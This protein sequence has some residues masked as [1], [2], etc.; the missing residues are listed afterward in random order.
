M[1]TKTDSDPFGTESITEVQLLNAPLA[2]VIVQIRFPQL[3]S[4]S[5]DD[6][7]AKRVI[8]SLAGRYPILQE[9]HSTSVTVGPDGAYQEVRGPATIWQLRSA[10]EA[11]QVS[12]CNTYIA[13]DTGA[14]VDRF[15]FLERFEQVLNIFSEIAEPPHFERLGFRYVNRLTEQAAISEI[16]NLVRPEILG[17]MAVSTSC[18]ELRQSISDSVFQIGQHTYLQARWGLLPPNVVADPSISMAPNPSWVLDIDVSTEDR[19]SMK[20]SLVISR[21][22]EL[23]LQGYRFFRWVVYDEFLDIHGAKK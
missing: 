7:T 6:E 5:S 2:R 3:A 14:Y 12:F 19:E 21:A 15:D 22:H 13:F 4:L 20:P 18:A 9:G 23:A 17:G 16:R 8:S 10:D 11:W 1:T